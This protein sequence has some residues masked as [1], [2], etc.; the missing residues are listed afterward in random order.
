MGTRD[1]RVDAYIAKS[2]DFAKPILT[3]IR[4]TVHA[5]CPDVEETLK[6]GMPA[7]DY[8]GMLCNMSS[9]K[10]HCRF[11]FWKGSLVLG[12]AEPTAPNG[13]FGNITSLKD[14]PNKRA[15]TG[16]VKK[17]AEL[18]A[19]GVKVQRA[20]KTAK[21]A[22]PVPDDLAAALKKNAKARATFEKFSPSHRR[23]Y[24]EWITEAKQQA[25]RERRLAQA[26]EW[27]AAG[28][29]RNWKYM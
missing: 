10:A 8:H 6:W 7:F 28:K 2:A 11:G 17:A 21:K 29:P 1:K 24:I 12:D 18:N 4:E 16:Y 25:T 14:L 22:L 9:F 15:L 27:M 13:H 26:V 23:E 20:P 19:G 5:A 3:Y